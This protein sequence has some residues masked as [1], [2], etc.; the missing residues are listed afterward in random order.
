M[1]RV[2]F[3]DSASLRPSSEYDTWPLTT[4]TLWDE[5]SNRTR[6]E[7]RAARWRLRRAEQPETW[8]LPAEPLARALCL[9]ELRYRNN[10]YCR[11]AVDG[12]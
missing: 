2:L 6:S 9:L 11:G 10:S 1:S 8:P 5:A 7:A 4:R 12:D 3:A